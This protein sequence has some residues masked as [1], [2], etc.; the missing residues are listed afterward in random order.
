[1]RRVWRPMPENKAAIP[2]VASLCCVALTMACW[3]KMGW[4]VAERRAEH[5]HLLA[6]HA[7]E[8]GA[9]DG[10]GARAHERDWVSRLPSASS[11]QAGASQLRE[12]AQAVGIELRQLNVTEYAATDTTL[13]RLAIELDAYGAYAGS[14]ELL[15]GVLSHKRNSLYVE[16]LSLRRRGT[17]STLDLRARLIWLSR[18][19]R[20]TGE[21][22][23]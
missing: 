1:M 2:L 3:L 7:G 12:A 10:I 4:E 5:K 18:P 19:V 16:N 17:A 20:G 11:M 8:F 22:K 23:Q 13:G 21:P 14:K 6:R 15:I 9:E